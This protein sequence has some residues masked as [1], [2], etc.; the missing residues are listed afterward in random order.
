MRVLFN[1]PV[2]VAYHL[3]YVLGEGLLPVDW[4]VAFAGQRNG[5][6]G[7]G[8]AG[9]L[10][11]V[12]TPHTA[13]DF[14]LRVELH[15]HEPALDDGWEEVVEV[16]FTPNS[17]KVSLTSW[18]GQHFPLALSMQSYRVRFHAAQ[19]DESDELEEQETPAWR[20]SLLQFWPAPRRPETP[21]C[22]GWA[23]RQS[24]RISTRQSFRIPQRR[25]RDPGDQ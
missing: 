10:L 14:P 5:L 3:L 17:A 23:T 20:G 2:M 18:E 9:G 24:F 16:S 6:C 8:G 7:A 21:L 22:S 15:E 1:G 12:A 4:N 19:M 25:H 11:L 13:S